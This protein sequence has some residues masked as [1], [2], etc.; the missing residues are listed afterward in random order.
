MDP[1]LGAILLAWFLLRGPAEDAWYSVKRQESPRAKTRRELQE[2]KGGSVSSKLAHAAAD[3]LAQRIANPKEKTSGPL[4]T[5]LSH[6]WADA[7]AARDDHRAQRAEDRRRAAA[8]DPEDTPDTPEGVHVDDNGQDSGQEQ[9]RR[10]W[11]QWNQPK[12]QP[13]PEP[14]AETAPQPVRAIA[15]RLDIPPDPQPA[16]DHRFHDHRR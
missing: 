10:K 9:S 8:G 13:E 11:W 16:A 4:R 6:L 12:P 2:R 5:Y 15:E 7:L 3:R 1:F 14:E